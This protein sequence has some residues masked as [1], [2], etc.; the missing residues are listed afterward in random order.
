MW[1]GNSSG[2]VRWHA[3]HM[4]YDTEV[5]IKEIVTGKLRLCSYVLLN[6]LMGR[7]I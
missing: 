1:L 2:R 5:A 4:V 3:R 7:H 6:G